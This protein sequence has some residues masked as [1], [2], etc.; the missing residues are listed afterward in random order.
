M[1]TGATLL[2]ADW[3]T[4]LLGLIWTAAVLPLAGNYWLVWIGVGR[5]SQ[6][7]AG[8]TQGCNA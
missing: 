6:H 7:T 5:K 8:V 3:A 2:I 4:G 1:R